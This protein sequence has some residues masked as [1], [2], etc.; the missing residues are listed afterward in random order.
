MLE[1]PL[2]GKILTNLVASADRSGVYWKV[3]GAVD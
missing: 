2:P 1:V 3:F